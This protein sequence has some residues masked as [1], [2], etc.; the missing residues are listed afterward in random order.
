MKK[1]E[2][3]DYTK[4]REKVIFNFSLRENAEA[5]T[6]ALSFAGYY[7][8]VMGKNNYG[9]QYVVCVYTDRDL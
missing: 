2:K 5:V 6:L 1:K 8:R 3:I 9:Q 7:V 4:V